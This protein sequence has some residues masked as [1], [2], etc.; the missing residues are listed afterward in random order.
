MVLSLTLESLSSKTTSILV[1][2][3]SI[4]NKSLHKLEGLQIRRILQVADGRVC[5][6]YSRS[7][8]NENY[9]NKGLILFGK[10]FTKFNVR[11]SNLLYYYLLLVTFQH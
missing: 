2:R 5:D 9:K 3:L 6:A 10:S 8:C 11:V 7:S 1:L 4:G